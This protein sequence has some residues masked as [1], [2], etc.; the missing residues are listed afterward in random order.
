MSA[1]Y[2]PLRSEPPEND[3][4]VPHETHSR[5]TFTMRNDP[6][7]YV[8]PLECGWG[9][10]FIPKLQTTVKQ[11]PQVL[12]GLS[13][14]FF[15]FATGSII[16]RE[17]RIS[18]SNAAILFW[19]GFVAVCKYRDFKDAMRVILGCFGVTVG[20]PDGTY[21]AS[22]GLL[23]ED[24]A[25]VA[26][27]DEAVKFTP[28]GR[29]IWSSPISTRVS[30]FPQDAVVPAIL[31]QYC[32][33]F[34]TDAILWTSIRVPEPT[35]SLW[36]ST[37]AIRFM[38]YVIQMV[39]L[40]SFGLPSLYSVVFFT[41]NVLTVLVLQ[42]VCTVQCYYQGRDYFVRNMIVLGMAV[43]VGAYLIGVVYS[44]SCKASK[45]A[46][47]G[48]VT[49]DPVVDSNAHTT[50]KAASRVGQTYIKVRRSLLPRRLQIAAMWISC[51][52]LVIIFVPLFAGM[53]CTGFS[54]VMYALFMTVGRF[55]ELVFVLLANVR[56]V[57]PAIPLIFAAVVFVG[58]SLQLATTMTCSGDSFALNLKVLVGVV[59]Y[60][61]V[62]VCTVFLY[63]YRAGQVALAAA[64]TESDALE[65]N[66]AP[67]RD[68]ELH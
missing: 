58:L 67:G 7:M 54:Q 60:G 22:E 27:Y 52:W 40:T 46:V 13:I 49:H 47:A 55:S 19:I 64:A 9:S 2:L 51:S 65:K 15:V 59:L 38:L 66:D 50:E 3:S 48:E 14:P 45:A 61:M 29:R 35:L 34:I 62:S 23:S 21:Q 16:Y 1:Q 32:W 36:M 63:H 12:Q 5:Q 17:G 8:V 4:Y 28:L 26:R 33:M 24:L 37:V 56:V 43:P 57:S 20:T 39:R 10:L 6:V 31:A 44:C 18:F 53:D 68:V 25:R 42:A 11:L 41:M 30:V